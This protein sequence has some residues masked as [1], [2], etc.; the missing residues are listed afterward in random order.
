[1]NKKDVEDL[2]SIIRQRAGLPKLGAAKERQPI[3]AGS[4]TSTLRERQP[5]GSGGGGIAS[6]LT[7]DTGTRTLHATT[8]LQ[9]SDGLFVWEYQ[10]I[11]T[12]TFT[13]ADGATVEVTLE[14]V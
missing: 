5:E 4:A 1:M 8:A 13:D 6:P 9:S 14:D 2:T 11:D 10:H 12:L 3:P 7:E